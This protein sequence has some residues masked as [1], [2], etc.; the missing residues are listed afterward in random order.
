MIWDSHGM[1]RGIQK[2]GWVMLAVA[3]AHV[4]LELKMDF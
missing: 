4:D 2:D 3:G 1:E